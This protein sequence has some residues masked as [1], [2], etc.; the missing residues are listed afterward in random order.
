MNGVVMGPNDM[1][2]FCTQGPQHIYLVDA[3]VACGVW[4]PTASQ[5][6]NC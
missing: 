1:A 2:L 3:G 6:D 4:P 5:Q